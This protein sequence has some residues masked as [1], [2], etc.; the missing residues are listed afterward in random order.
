MVWSRPAWPLKTWAC[1]PNQSVF[2]AKQKPG[3]HCENC[4][5][6]GNR[7]LLSDPCGMNTASGCFCCVRWG[8]WIWKPES[9]KGEICSPFSFLGHIHDSLAHPVLS[10]TLNYS[11][12]PQAPAEHSGHTNDS[13]FTDKIVLFCRGFFW[14]GSTSLNHQRETKSGG[15]H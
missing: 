14:W 4:N 3:Q 5:R 7:V 8:L 12:R 11:A 15:E 2:R 10:E 6:N 13:H 1:W 9:Q